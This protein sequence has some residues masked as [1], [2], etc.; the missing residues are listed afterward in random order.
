M[1]VD[2]RR[3]HDIAAV[4][5]KRGIEGGLRPADVLDAAFAVAGGE[6]GARR[7]A[8]RKL[9][10]IYAAC[11]AADQCRLVV[12]PEGHRFYADLAWPAM[13]KAE[14]RPGATAPA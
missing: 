11:G 9:K 7:R 5:Q 10:G 13:Q 8:F 1:R 3:G 2:P 4:E 12:G 14:S 6:V